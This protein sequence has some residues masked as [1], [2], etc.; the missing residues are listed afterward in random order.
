MCVQYCEGYHAGFLAG[1]APWGSLPPWKLLPVPEI[2]SENNSITKEICIT[3]DFAPL[4]KNPG[5]KASMS[6]VGVILST[7]GDTQYRGGYHDARGDIMSTV[8]EKIFCYLNT[9]RYWTPPHGTD[10][11]SPHVA[12]YPPRYSNYK[13]WYPPV[14]MT[15]PPRYWALPTVLNTRYTRWLRSNP[16][17]ALRSERFIK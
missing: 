11:I 4:E 1:G 13:G 9:P 7:V 6:T 15:P 16:N 8:R 5:D 10:D 3:I 14:L 2:W 12:W 17:Q